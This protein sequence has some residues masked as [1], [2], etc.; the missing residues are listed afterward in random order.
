MPTLENRKKIVD[1]YLPAFQKT[2]LVMLVNGQE[3]TTY[4]VQHGAGWRADC[5]G[6]PG[7]FLTNVVPHARC[8]PQMMREAK[9][10]DAWNK[11]P[12]CLGTAAG[13]C[14][15]GGE[16]PAVALDLQLRTGLVMASYFSG[17]SAS[18]PDSEKF[19]PELE[20]FLR[21]LG[22]R[23]V[24]K[25]LKHPATVRPGEKLQLTMKWQNVGS[26]P[27]YKPYRVAYRLANDQGYEQVIV[28]TVSVNKWLPGSIELF[29]EEFFQEPA[30]LP[31][32]EVVDVAD[33]IQLPHDLSPGTY[34][35]S[36]AVVGTED[37][38]PLVRLGIK[39][40]AEDGWY[41]LSTVTISGKKRSG[42]M[43]GAVISTNGIQA[44]EPKRAEQTG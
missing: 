20:R 25:E 42:D 35:L 28:G 32:G 11:G 24:L 15:V 29:T 6:G 23:L 2:P 5:D 39:G 41:P 7:Q 10:E 22:Y 26:A 31:P 43:I 18:L 16:G 36:I 1:A 3:C 14:G 12:D 37:T 34:T 9:A 4:A 21:R 30:D 44:R 8:L 33:S 40:R 27:C 13:R 19:R 17:K 38:K